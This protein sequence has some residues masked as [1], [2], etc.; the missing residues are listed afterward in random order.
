MAAA[1]RTIVKSKI[2]LHCL[3]DLQLINYSYSADSFIHSLTLCLIAERV[4]GVLVCSMALENV[5]TNN[6]DLGFTRNDCAN[7]SPASIS[8]AS[9]NNEYCS[10]SLSIHS[11]VTSAY[12]LYV[13]SD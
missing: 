3:G 7:S 8:V 12:V 5:P 13:G 2:F 6:F 10:P 11:T 4:S 1:L 9:C